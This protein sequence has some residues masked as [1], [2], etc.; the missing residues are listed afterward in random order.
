MS[1][2]LFSGQHVNSSSVHLL[3]ADVSPWTSAEFMNGK[4]LKDL[5]SRYHP[6]I[7]LSNVKLAQQ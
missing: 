3:D 5:F 2:L 4:N 6:F 7:S 1:G